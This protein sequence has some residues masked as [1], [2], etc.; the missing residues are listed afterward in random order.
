M[1]NKTL[2]V[3]AG[4][5]VYGTSLPHAWAQKVFRCPAQSGAY[6]FSD[7]PCS[8]TWPSEQVRLFPNS[9][10]HAGERELQ[11]RQENAQLREQLNARD[12]ASGGGSQGRT[13][14]DFRAE[15]VD[16]KECR[17]ARR[18]YEV[19]AGSRLNAPALIEA[20]RASMLVACGR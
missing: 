6:E 19:T 14:A 18:D 8:P 1:L 7:V 12:Q 20:K 16:A 2:I 9:I 13:V 17:M 11:L 3:V 4:M 15:R 5:L 10:S